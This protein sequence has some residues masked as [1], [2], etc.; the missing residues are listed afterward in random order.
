MA[1]TVC[2]LC[3]NKRRTTP[4]HRRSGKG[5]FKEALR[6]SALRPARSIPPA[7]RGRHATNARGMDDDSSVEARCARIRGR[8]VWILS[9]LEGD[10]TALQQLAF[11]PSY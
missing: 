10:S 9:Q 8:M 6:L 3:G 4:T 11:N 7:P 2:V 5:A 1:Y